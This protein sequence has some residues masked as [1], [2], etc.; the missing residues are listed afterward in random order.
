MCVFSTINA[1]FA[2]KKSEKNQCDTVYKVYVRVF[3]PCRS[4][5]FHVIDPPFGG[6]EVKPK[7]IDLF[8]VFFF[9]IVRVVKVQPMC[10]KV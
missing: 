3:V 8:F 4:E 2:W 7:T 9:N 10:M 6:I 1:S 5:I